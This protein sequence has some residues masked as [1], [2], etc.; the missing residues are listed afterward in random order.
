ME[1]AEWDQREDARPVRTAWSNTASAG[2]RGRARL[3]PR[4]LRW[5]VSRGSSEASDLLDQFDLALARLRSLI[6]PRRSA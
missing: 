6:V 4:S 2:Q 3:M 1:H 5:Y